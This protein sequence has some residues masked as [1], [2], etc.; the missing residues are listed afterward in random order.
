MVVAGCK[1]GL[2]WLE[3]V[4]IGQ[5]HV[6]HQHRAKRHGVRQSSAA[7]PNLTQFSSSR[8]YTIPFPVC[9]CDHYTNRRFIEKSFA[10][11]NPINSGL[12]LSSHTSKTEKSRA[13]AVQGSKSGER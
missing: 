11:E 12:S 2:N 1:S 3:S 6:G 7:F 8:R 13:Q 5:I 9:N 4:G 10:A